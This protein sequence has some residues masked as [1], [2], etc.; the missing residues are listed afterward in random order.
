MFEIFSNNDTELDELLHNEDN[1]LVN[2]I[3]EEFNIK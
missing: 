2:S 1:D 3:K